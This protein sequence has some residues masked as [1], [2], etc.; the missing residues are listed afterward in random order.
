MT[1]Q[2]VRAVLLSKVA[3]LTDPGD[4][5][6]D[7]GAGLG[8]VSVEI[9]VL[10]PHVEVVAVERDSVRAQC[11]RRNCER[12]DTYNVRAIEGVAPAVLAREIDRPRLVFIGGSGENFGPIL[13]LAAGRLLNGGRLLAN[14]VTL[15]NLCFMLQRLRE[16]RWQFDVTEVQ[17]SRSD[18]LGPHTG[19]KPQRGVFIVR[20]DK[21]GSNL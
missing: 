13:E 3:G 1:R 11:L 16:W 14:F 20:A 2:E 8:T 18:N 9:A 7:I 10:R 4:V 19:L 17:V 6:W 21:A 15:E 5:V 12:F